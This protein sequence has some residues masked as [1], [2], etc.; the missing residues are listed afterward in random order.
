[1]IGAAIPSDQVH[2]LTIGIEIL[3]WIKK[4]AKNSYKG[5]PTCER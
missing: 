5:I 1:M 3:T 4:D 2:K